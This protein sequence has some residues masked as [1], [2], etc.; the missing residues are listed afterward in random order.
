[1]E[2]AKP[3]TTRRW[4]TI[5]KRSSPAFQNVEDNLAALRVLEQEAE[6]EDVAVQAAQR[7][8]VLS[9][10]QY[11]GGVTSY[12]TVLTAQS[13]ALADERSAVDILRRRIDASVLLIKALGGGW[14]VTTNIPRADA[15]AG[16]PGGGRSLRLV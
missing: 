7:S 4:P 5:A 10:N 8:V 9:P 12:L 13:S 3:P 1:M 11:K 14:D 2:Q 15:V 6:T 16:T